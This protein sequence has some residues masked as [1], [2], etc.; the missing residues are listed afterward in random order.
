MPKIFNY[1]PKRWNFAKSG[2]TATTPP[3][4][5]RYSSLSRIENQCLTNY[6]RAVVVAQLVE[7]LLPKPETHCSNSLIG[8]SYLLPFVLTKEKKKR[9]GMA[10][11]HRKTSPSNVNT[12][13]QSCVSKL[14]H[15]MTPWADVINKFHRSQSPF[16]KKK[17]A[18]PGLFLF[19]FVLF[20]LKLQ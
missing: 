13:W 1:L 18:Y 14:S 17:L 16:Y 20:S 4:L 15:R 6:D 12:F 19:T 8:N 10:Q 2:H 5:H 9:S 11:L 7:Q 3:P